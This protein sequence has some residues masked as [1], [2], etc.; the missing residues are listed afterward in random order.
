MVASVA[1]LA[2]GREA[3]HFDRVER[4]LTLNE[5]DLAYGLGE[6]MEETRS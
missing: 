4:W 5:K 2:A 6:R 1:G 3:A